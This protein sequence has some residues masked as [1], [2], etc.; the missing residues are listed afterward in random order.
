MVE[1]WMAGAPSPALRWDASS[2]QATPA[3]PQGGGARAGEVNPYFRVGFAWPAT[4]YRVAPPTFCASK[5]P[6]SCSGVWSRR[7][8]RAWISMRCIYTTRWWIGMYIYI[9]ICMHI[10]LNVNMHI[11]VHVHMHVNMHRRIL[12]TLQRTHTVQPTFATPTPRRLVASLDPRIP[13]PPRRLALVPIHRPFRDR[14]KTKKREHSHSQTIPDAER[15]ASFST[16]GLLAPLPARDQHAGGTPSTTCTAQ[17]S[18]RRPP[19]RTVG[20]ETLG[21]YMEEYDRGHI[22]GI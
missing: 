18:V 22:H 13:S 16:S 9:H 3:P 6:S 5:A 17:G 21:W 7:V 4:K 19:L 11:Y 10:N 15:A 1:S 2:S 12:S 8:S 14:G 20:E